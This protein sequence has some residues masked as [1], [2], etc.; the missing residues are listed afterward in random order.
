MT[1]IQ[2]IIFH[3]NI[4][5]LFCIETGFLISV[6]A[7]L[8]FRFL[9]NSLN[10]AAYEDYVQNKLYKRQQKIIKKKSLSIQVV[11]KFADLFKTSM[12]V[13]SKLLLLLFCYSTQRKKSSYAESYQTLWKRSKRTCWDR[14]KGCPRYI[15]PKAQRRSQILAW[16]SGGCEVGTSGLWKEHWYT[17][18]TLWE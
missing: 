18:Q 5:G 6:S 10:H 15:N 12:M 16:W 2:N 1:V 3:Q 17:W 4:I 14:G 9:G 7:S 8:L 13:S 11:P